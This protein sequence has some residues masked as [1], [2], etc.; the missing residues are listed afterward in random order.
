MTTGGKGTRSTAFCTMLETWGGKDG[1]DG[2]AG[3]EFEILK[4][5]EKE[6][7]GTVKVVRFL[8]LLLN[9]IVL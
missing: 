7:C 1:A 3:R 4:I 9:R 2:M 6:M 8:V 5:E